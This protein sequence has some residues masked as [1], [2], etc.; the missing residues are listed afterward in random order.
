MIAADSSVAV[1]AFASWHA[2]HE[3][4]LD[5]LGSEALVPAH[6]ALETYS[7]LTRLPQPLRVPAGPVV[8]FLSNRFTRPWLVLGGDATLE[9][10][11]ELRT[12]GIAGGATYDATIAATAR[13]SGVKLVSCDRRAAAVY[14]RLGVGFEL[15]S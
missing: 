6:A 2:L 9:L 4:A 5:A 10:L 15:I 14:E 12:L 1:A 11:E 7:V 13:A 3:Q 8:E